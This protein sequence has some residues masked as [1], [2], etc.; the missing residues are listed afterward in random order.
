MIAK[1]VRDRLQKLADENDGALTADIV[2]KDAKDPQS[3]L[4][5]QA[6]FEWNMSKAAE[7]NWLD[8][9]R[10]LIR[11]VR[12]VF[13]TETVKIKSIAY[14]RDPRVEPNTQGYVS[15][16]KLKTDKDHAREALQYEIER[17]LAHMQRAK[18]V[19]MA[20]ELEDEF[21][22]ILDSLVTLRGVV[23]SNLETKSSPEA[24]TLN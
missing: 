14:V 15:V 19:A 1:V 9:A 5:T 7:Q 22:G 10:F 3:P 11:S 16:A 12:I 21:Q 8:H 4:H 20:L 13:K 6:G 2:V 23:V 17:A 18:E 24:T